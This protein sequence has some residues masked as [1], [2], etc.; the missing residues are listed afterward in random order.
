M[1]YNVHDFFL[2]YNAELL[3]IFADYIENDFTHCY[4]GN[5]IASSK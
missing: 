1:Q 4:N 5:W 3:H 2:L